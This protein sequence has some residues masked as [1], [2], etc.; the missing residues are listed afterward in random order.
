MAVV[1]VEP[2]HMPPVRFKCQTWIRVGPRRAIATPEEERRLIERQRGA[3]LPLLAAALFAHETAA[4]D[5]D[6]SASLDGDGGNG[7]SASLSQA[8][9]PD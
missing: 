2:S 5:E 8:G 6:D 3:A 1:I 7:G 9:A 4:L